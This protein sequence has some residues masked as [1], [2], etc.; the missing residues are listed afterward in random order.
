MPKSSAELTQIAAGYLLA[1]GNAAKRE[2]NKSKV[3]KSKVSEPRPIQLGSPC[4]S[5]N[6]PAF[7]PFVP[8]HNPY[9]GYQ[10]VKGQKIYK[11]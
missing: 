10:V 2:E 5:P 3:S 8:T 7:T 6:H 4:L 1:A 9:A 11:K